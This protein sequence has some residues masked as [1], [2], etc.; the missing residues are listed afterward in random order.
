MLQQLN[1]GLLFNLMFVLIIVFAVLFGYLR[2]LKK[3]IYTFIV[4][5]VFLLF[6]IITI[7][8]MVNMLWSMNILGLGSL[9]GAIIPELSGV[10]SFK[11]ALPL[12]LELYLGDMLS[13]SITNE[14]FIAFTTGLGLFVFK[15]A[16]TIVY[17]TVVW[18]LYRLVFLIVRFIFVKEDK[19]AEKP[20][21]LRRRRFGA[22]F[23]VLNAGLTIYALIIILGGFMSIAESVESLNADTA[24][25]RSNA[26][27]VQD[28]WVPLSDP[29]VDLDAFADI[30]ELVDNV[31]DG[32]NRTVFVRIA[33]IFRV[34][35]P[36]SDQR[37]AIHLR[38]FD[39]VFS[40][41]YRDENISVRKELAILA[42]AAGIFLNS[43]FIETQDIADIRPDDVRDIFETASGSKLFIA[44]LPL[45]IE[46]AADYFDVDISVERE[47]LYALDWE[48]EIKQLGQIAY[49]MLTI[50]HYAGLLDDAL[51]L[52]T[53]TFD[54]EQ[55]QALFDSLADSALMTL[56]AY[57]AMETVLREVGG[58]VEAVITIP[59]GL[60]WDA[61]FRALGYIVNQIV[62]TNITLGDINAGD[63]FAILGILSAVD[64]TILI[65]SKLI[66]YAA[67]NILTGAL[68]IEAL[69]MIVVPDTVIWFD[70]DGNVPVGG[71]LFTILN[72]VNEIAK[73]AGQINLDDLDL[74]FLHDLS[75]DI[76]ASIFASQIVE[77]TLGSLLLNLDELGL[78]DIEEFLVIPSAAKKTIMVN[79]EARDIVKADELLLIFDFFFALDIEDY[80]DLL[81]D[82][83]DVS[84]LK[85]FSVSEEESHVLNQALADKLLASNI[86]HASVSTLVFNQLEELELDDMVT[87][88]HL[89]FDGEV[90]VYTDP[91][92]DIKYISRQEI[93]NV[94]A[95]ALIVELES[96]EALE[97]MAIDVAGVFE[98]IDI[99]LNS[100]IIHATLTDLLLDFTE[101]ALADFEI[102]ERTIEIFL[103][104]P[105][106]DDSGQP[107]RILVGEGQTDPVTGEDVS[108]EYISKHEVK[109][110]VSFA[111]SL[112]VT[113]D[114]KVILDAL[115]DDDPLALD[116][117]V[118]LENLF[119]DSEHAALFDSSIVQGT[120]SKALLDIASEP[121]FVLDLDM[122][123]IELG[124]QVPF[125][126]FDG[127]PIRIEVGEGV[128][129]FEYITKAELN[130]FLEILDVA[131]IDKSV[132]NLLDTIDGGEL[133]DILTL[134]E[135]K[136]LLPDDGTSI[137]FES[138]IL[139]ATI[140]GALFSALDNT[141]AFDMPD[142]SI[143]E[144]N[145]TLPYY[146]ED[147]NVIRITVG[148]GDEAFEFIAKSELQVFLNMVD[149]L[150][151]GD[152]YERV[153][154]TLLDLEDDFGVL[155]TILTLEPLFTDPYV[156]LSSSIIRSV[157]SQALIQA[158]DEVFVL[159]IGDDV[160]DLALPMPFYSIAGTPVRVTQGAG[161]RA[162]EYI[163]RAE[164]E[165]LFDILN[166]VLVDKTFTT[167]FDTLDAL[168][169]GL[170]A[171]DNLISLD[172]I[173]D[174]NSV[175]LNSAIIHA[176]LSKALIDFIDT[177]LEVEFTEELSLDVPVNV[178]YYNVAGESIRITVGAGERATEYVV[179]F[180]IQSFINMVDATL[181]TR[182]IGDILEAIDGLDDGFGGLDDIIDIDGL[183]NDDSILLDSAIFHAFVSRAIFSLLDQTL[184]FD[185]TDDFTLDIVLAVPFYDEDG[186][187]VRILVEDDGTV[188]FLANGA[189]SRAI[190]YISRAEIQH[191]L[192]IINSALV[193]RNIG[194]ILDVLTGDLDDLTVL[195][196]LFSLEK[197][198]GDESL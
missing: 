137:L 60:D 69:D 106:L 171:L 50:V 63:P 85:L 102:D 160:Y 169:D 89:S 81:P 99:V 113:T 9:L 140:S 121:L 156:L 44:I 142:G 12:I 152:D 172:A 87:I 62:S 119:A 100:A 193:E 74:N 108:R 110:L 195:N 33:G 59:V 91:I 176:V 109:N 115:E 143:F 184:S 10:G 118:S 150:I 93:K 138:A 83:I 73:V 180:E 131:L 68:D 179:D 56:T 90:V 127:T 4:K 1:F 14:E 22:L 98:H 129:A 47:E 123:T 162:T 194:T 111:R 135:V 86:L 84:L 55:M 128:T 105:H 16:Y 49:A 141:F 177:T 42:D 133:V 126:T 134:L 151:I 34:A 24:S 120:L 189:V 124:L 154:S 186:N 5:L 25:L 94:L 31:T 174:P 58:M 147:G 26:L 122:T 21:K 96:L 37:I 183:L 163:V 198:L 2:G 125:T 114:L 23:G 148:A 178:P 175:L 161:E 61:E 166:S 27:N 187:P 130:R 168:D 159:E 88:P 104:V 72:A 97:E 79:E 17:F 149:T 95:L 30:F 28:E 80:N 82:N 146:T 101:E 67:I 40:F 66:S 70:E 191:L 19:E 192:N 35:D 197:L 181:T 75:Y 41:K 158:G 8:G 32:F 39:R 167:I 13:T 182:S 52:E 164:M 157:V 38:L 46:V 45:A 196:D 144:L 92:D 54:G 15:V 18:A 43:K 51:D 170:G 64:F 78:E 190:E 145:L 48:T 107:V 117:V 188:V 155:D 76:I 77:A 165:I 57:V 112:L 71:E 132:G 65:E 3:T 173:L 185:L 139:H 153:A 103:V 136:T 20:V 116:A 53:V 29:L 6:F 11:E 36:D 7:N